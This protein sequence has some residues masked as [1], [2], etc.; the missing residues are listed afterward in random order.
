MPHVLHRHLSL[1]ALA[2]G[3]DA[4]A[5]GRGVGL[6]LHLA[7]RAKKERL[8]TAES[9]RGRSASQVAANLGVAAIA[10]QCS[11]AV[12]V[13]DSRWFAQTTLS[14]AFALRMALAALAEAAAD[15]ASSEVG[16]VFGGLPR[17][18]T[19]CAR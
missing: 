19:T 14:P 13:I 12:L 16:Q 4:G 9:R 6:C 3:P 10:I 2:H 15:T 1:S 7:G 18:I 11:R 17:M 8:G 5:G